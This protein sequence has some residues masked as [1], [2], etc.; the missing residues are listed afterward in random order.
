MEAPMMQKELVKLGAGTDDYEMQS[1][2]ALKKRI[3]ENAIAEAR[4][5]AQAS[6]AQ[7]RSSRSSWRSWG[8]S[9]GGHPSA[10]LRSATTCSAPSRGS[11]EASDT[12]GAIT[13]LEHG[14]SAIMQSPMGAGRDKLA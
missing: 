13:A 1:Y 8:S 5:E 7:D 4:A 11:S 3:Y 14:L 6:L 2:E 10:A 9:A 12:Y